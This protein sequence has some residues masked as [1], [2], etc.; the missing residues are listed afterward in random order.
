MNEHLIRGGFISLLAP[1]K[2]GKTFFLID[3]A[4]R[5]SSQGCKVAFFQAGDMTRN[6]Q[7]RR[8]AIYRAKKSDKEKYCGKRLIPVKDCIHNQLDRCDKDQRECDYGIFDGNELSKFEE[9]LRKEI[10]FNTLREK[11][12]E[13]PD[14][15]NCHNC[16][17]YRENPWGTV[18]LKEVDTGNPLNV[19]EAKKMMKRFFI[20]KKRRFK[21]STHANGT[22]SVKEMN[23][24]MNEWEKNDGFVPD[25]I[26]IDYADLLIYPE[27]DFRHQQNEIWKALRGLSQKRHSLVITVTQADAKSYDQDSLKLSNYSEDKRKYAHVTAMWGMNQDP[28]GREKKMGLM[29]FNEL[30]IREGEFDAGRQIHVLQ[31][32]SQGQAFLTSYW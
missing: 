6:Q 10:D 26:I 15:K 20:D 3:M 16:L 7:I 21:L 24:I 29:R 13:Y 17:E 31:S 27:K 11:L 2:R 32:L 28:K 12:E 8:L 4:N 14:Y 23:S 1:E 19:E 18:W 9:G 22:L 25:V 30:V 5:A